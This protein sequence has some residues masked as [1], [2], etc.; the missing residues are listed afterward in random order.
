MVRWPNKSPHPGQFMLTCGT[1]AAAAAT[2]SLWWVG[3]IILVYGSGTWALQA[4]E[5]SEVSVF[6]RRSPRNVVRIWYDQDIGYVKGYGLV[7]IIRTPTRETS[8]W[9]LYRLHWLCHVLRMPS[10]SLPSRK[11]LYWT[12]TLQRRPDDDLLVGHQ[13]SQ[14]QTQPCWFVAP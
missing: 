8:W 7:F 14:Q 13:D 3:F 9:P 6:G 5:R 1:Y 10:N 4:E 11:V 2:A 12:E